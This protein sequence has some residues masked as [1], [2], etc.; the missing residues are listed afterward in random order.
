MDQQH[1]HH[2]TIVDGAWLT[3]QFEVDDEK[4]TCHHFALSSV[5]LLSVGA[6]VCC[7]WYLSGWQILWHISSSWLGWT[8]CTE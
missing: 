8:S 3:N 5:K 2:F 7:R 1:N 6:D 4:K